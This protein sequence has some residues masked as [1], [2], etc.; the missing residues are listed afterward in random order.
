MD[1]KG[2]HAVLRPA[3][4]VYTFFIGEL[5]NFLGVSDDI[6]AIII[7]LTRTKVPIGL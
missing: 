4:Q 1:E 6:Y 3:K 2:T 5:C 7:L